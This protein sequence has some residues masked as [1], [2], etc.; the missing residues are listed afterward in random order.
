MTYWIL[1]LTVLI[2]GFLTGFSIG[3]FIFPIGVALLLLGP[4]RHRPRVFWPILMGVV[5]CD[6]GYLLFVPL[7]C[8]ATATIPGGVTETTCT[9]ILG[10]DYRA[11]GTA[12]PPT[13]V[14]LVVGGLVG[15]G[16]AVATLVVLTV[17]GRHNDRA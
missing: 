11:Q 6:I 13:D 2:A 10:P 7:T 14:A 16:A 3:I 12:S 5:G 8:T 17:S 9:S 15:A 1:T 4:V